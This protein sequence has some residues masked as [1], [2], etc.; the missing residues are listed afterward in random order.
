[1]D[2]VLVTGGAGFI[3][4]H[5]VRRLLRDENIS[6]VTVLDALTYAGTVYNLDGVL[7]HPRLS[8]IE[9]DILDGTVVADLVA[10][11]DAV[12]HL[13]AESHV[14]RSFETT[15]KF[16]A[17]NVQGTR[18]LLDAAAQ[19]GVRK[20][21]HVSTDE[22][23]GPLPTGTACENDPLR[24]TNPYAASKAAS[25]MVANSYFHTYGVPVCITRSTN[26]YGPGQHHE[27]IVPAFV[28]SLLAGGRVSIHGHG[29]HIRNWLHVE[30]NCRGIELVLHKGIPGEIYNIGG[31]TGL[32][33]NELARTV[34]RAC[35]ADWSSVDY[36][37]DRR[38]NDIRYSM[39]WTKAARDLGYRP[40]RSL[41]EGLAET[42]QWYRRHPDRWVTSPTGSAQAAQDAAPDVVSPVP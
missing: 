14:D 37:S 35:G 39:D 28:T 8:F 7:N 12:V 23:Y 26:N 3:G 27:K 20:F 5:F 1:M 16:V 4:S 18:M 31:G 42:V 17:T 24:P 38:S 33:N 36:V 11:H 29:E 22:V 32:T 34:L 9:G 41:I 30:D 40:I 19:L 10:T 13:A 15:E 6:R 21:V 2:R 25:D